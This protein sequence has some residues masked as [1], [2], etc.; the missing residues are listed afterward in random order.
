MRTLLLQDIVQHLGLGSRFGVS[1]E[2]DHIVEIPWSG[3]VT[4]CT[5]LFRERFLIGVA[6]D[7]DSLRRRV[8]VVVKD[9]A[10][11]R[12]QDEKLI[13]S[14][15]Q[16]D[17]RETT[18]ARSDRPPVAELALAGHRAARVFEY[19][20]FLE[21]FGDLDSGPLVDPFSDFAEDAGQEA[22]IDVR[23]I[24]KREVEVFGEAVGF[25]IAFLE[26]GPALEYSAIGEGGRLVDA[27]EN[28]TQHVVL[29]DDLGSQ[30]ERTGDIVN[31]AA[32]D[33]AGAT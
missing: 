17:A 4:K 11:R 26:A 19:L 16:L 22:T 6:Q 28:P 24:G 15:I 10:S 25:E 14:K 13:G 18:R 31:F 32:V 30:S 1:I 5:N 20:E 2:I 8:A 21:L 7:S 27:S 23:G 29:L 9:G 33:H 3:T 12:P